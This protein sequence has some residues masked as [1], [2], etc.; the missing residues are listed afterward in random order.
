MCIVGQVGPGGGQACSIL[1]KEHWDMDDSIWEV[2]T[3]ME[4][5]LARQL[6]PS[7]KCWSGGRQQLWASPEQETIFK[8]QRDEIDKYVL[9]LNNFV[10]NKYVE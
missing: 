6:N 4:V 2:L 8:R 7:S 1:V 9:S 3:T 5:I 10:L